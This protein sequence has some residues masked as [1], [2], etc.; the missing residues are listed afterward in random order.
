MNKK[1]IE[2]NIPIVSEANSH[3]KQKEPF[4][5]TI[6]IIL[7]LLV[8]VGGYL[9]FNQNRTNNKIDSIKSFEECEKAGYPVLQSDPEQ[10]GAPGGKLFYGDP[11]FKPPVVKQTTPRPVQSQTDPTADWKTYKDAQLGIEFKYPSDWVQNPAGEGCCTSVHAVKAKYPIGT[12]SVEAGYSK[13]C[14]DDINAAKN[15]GLKESTR[16]IN[17][18]PVTIFEGDSSYENTKYYRKYVLIASPSL[19]FRLDAGSTSSVD[20]E[21]V[22]QILSTFKFL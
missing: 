10:C 18:N 15:Y 20:Q 14:E 9:L 13:L 4:A 1:N 5:L 7:S 6:G 8:L 11:S 2:A 3:P 17:E 16:I 12:F 22:D 19:C 21:V